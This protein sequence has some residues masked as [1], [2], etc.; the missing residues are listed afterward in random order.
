MIL[1]L[2]NDGDLSV[3]FVVNWLRFY[4]T[5]FIRINSYDLLDSKFIATNKHLIINEQKIYPKEIKSVWFRKFGFFRES[6]HNRILETIVSPSASNH[7]VT[8]FNRTLSFIN[9]LFKDAFWLTNPNFLP[10]NKVKVLALASE[11][12][13]KTPL[14]YIVNSKS[15]LLSIFNK[16]PNGLISKSI[17]DPYPLVLDGD[18]YMMFTTQITNREINSLPDLFIPSLV[19]EKINKEYEVRTFFLE[20][21]CFS[22]AIMSQNDKQTSL[23]FRKYNYGKPNRYLPYKLSNDIEN[24]ISYL[25]SK[26]GLNTG[27]LDFIVNKK[28][29]L[30]FLEI[31]PTGQFGMVD[32][33]CNYG[34]HK[35]IAELLINKFSNESI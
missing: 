14:T 2:S 34:L 13:F 25:M 5:K 35:K 8:E 30:I 16:T 28:G 17:Y 22:M 11:L 21:Q 4:K 29:E 12:G 18:K 33:P 24:K 9:F 1:I 19:Q 31:N 20:G 7:I 23:D 15:D 10:L 6:N 26:L 32:F 3:D 27:S